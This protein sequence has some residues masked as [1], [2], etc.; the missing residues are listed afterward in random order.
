[1][2]NKIEK[3]KSYTVYMHVSPS[4]K[5]YIGITS[6]KPERRWRK[7]GEGYMRNTYFWNAIQRYG[8]DNF[9]HEVLFE[10]LTKDEAEQKEIELIAFYKS[11]DN[12]F[13]YNIEH[14]GNSIGKIADETKEKLR[15]LYSM[16]VCQYSK[17]GDFIKEYNSMTEAEEITNL[18]ASSI[19][20]CCRNEA[21]LC[22]NYIWR[23]KD[24]LPDSQLINWCNSRKPSSRKTKVS[25]YDKQGHL[26]KEYESMTIA[27]EETNIDRT[28]IIKCCKGE[29][30]VAGGYIWRYSD[31]LLTK[32]HLQWCISMLPKRVVQYTKNGEFIKIY[33]N[34]VSGELS[35]GINARGILSCCNG[36]RKTAGGY[37]WRNE[38]EELTENY[39]QWC[40]TRKT[41]F[42][43][44]FTGKSVIQY[45]ING[46]FVAIYKSMAEAEQITGV[47]RCNIS[48]CCN[49]HRNNAKGYIWRYASDVQDPYA[50]LF[51]TNQI[52]PQ[53][54]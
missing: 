15:I 46:V 31:E 4:G 48:L 20:K 50:P 13:G 23:F 10:N 16:P 22:G 5:R 45:S 26:V 43:R 25:Q 24:E 11:D 18:S 35:T 21:K 37:I 7:N 19:S 34:A 53:A 32:E 33:E 52:P 54:I 27:Y 29:Q 49:G 28:S 14:G 12:K 42:Y 51:P 3:D 40:N 38:G 41:D 9:T 8:W 39:I 30:G 6:Q 2:S 36:D 47:K 44:G 17:Y 1:M